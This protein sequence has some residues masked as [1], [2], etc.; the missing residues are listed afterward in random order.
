MRL[1]ERKIINGWELYQVNWN[2]SVELK[3]LFVVNISLNSPS[4]M[5]TYWGEKTHDHYLF[6][7]SVNR[8]R[9]C[10]YC[11]WKGIERM[12]KEADKCADED[13]KVKNQIHPCNK[14]E[15]YM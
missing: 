13:K 14:F 3:A 12:A 5:S 4:I 10:Y 1:C 11:R 9:K 15:L 2:G 6:K 7:P 8:S